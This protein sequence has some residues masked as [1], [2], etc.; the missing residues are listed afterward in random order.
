MLRG[1]AVFVI[2]FDKLR[3]GSWNFFFSVRPIFALQ[4]DV[5]G[6]VAEFDRAI[7]LDQRQKKCMYL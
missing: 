6:S 5:A 7:E 3:E 2:S 4:G 1:E